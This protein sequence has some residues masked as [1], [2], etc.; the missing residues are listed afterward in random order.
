MRGPYGHT[1]L[2]IC[3]AKLVNVCY[4]IRMKRRGITYIHLYR[5]LYTTKDVAVHHELQYDCQNSSYHHDKTSPQ[6]EGL[7]VHATADVE[8]GSAYRRTNKC[9]Y[10]N[11]SVDNASDT[12]KAT[13]A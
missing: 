2:L 1:F 8:N 4:A 9:S 10:G 6:L 5:P 13:D 11:T 7:V 12:S 3:L